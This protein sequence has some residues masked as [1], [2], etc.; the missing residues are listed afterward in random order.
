MKSDLQKYLD[1]YNQIGIPLK[2]THESDGRK[3]IEIRASD[4][5]LLQDKLGGYVNLYCDIVFDKYEK[6]IGQN[7]L[8]DI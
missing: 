2:V 4:A 1:M 5:P 6:F 7:F 8:M 3:I